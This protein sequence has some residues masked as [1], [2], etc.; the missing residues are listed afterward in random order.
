MDNSVSFSLIYL[1]VFLV[2]GHSYLLLSLQTT[3][4]KY[5]KQPLSHEF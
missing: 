1:Y 4:Y 3:A 2:S 5:Q